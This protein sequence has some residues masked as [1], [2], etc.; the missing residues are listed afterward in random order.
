MNDN[1]VINVTN[2]EYTDLLGVIHVR[3]HCFVGFGFIILSGQTLIESTI[4]GA[5]NVVI[6]SA[7]EIGIGIVGNPVKINCTVGEYKKHKQYFVNLN[8][9]LIGDISNMI[10]DKKIF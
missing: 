5:G 3:D 10:W 4:I 1:A 6:K 8:D 2:G 9:M 7:L